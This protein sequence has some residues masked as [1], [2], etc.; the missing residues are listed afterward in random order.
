M[1]LQPNHITKFLKNET[2]TKFKSELI[3]LLNKRIRFLCFEECERDR[4]VC[5]LTP[6]C[7]KRFLLKL[8]IKNDLKIEDLPKFC[9][10]VHK[11]VIERDFRNKRVVYKPNDAFLYLIDFLDIF[12][13][14]DYRKLNKFMSF[15]NW[16]ESIKIF[17]D[18]IQNRNE[19]FKY[20]LTSNFFIFKFE[21]NVHIIFINEK[22]VLCNANRENITDLELLIGICRIFAEEYFPE[23]NLKFVPS[24]NV[25]ITVM[26]PYDVLSKVIDNPSEEF[27]SKA[28]EYFWNIFWEDLNTLTN[29][30]EEIHLQMDKNQNLEI[31]LSIS[32]LTNNY[33]DDGKRVPLRF[34]DLRLILNFITQIYTDY[35]IVW[36]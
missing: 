33:S 2:E 29:Y 24:K 6:L 28:D 7:S 16:E 12:F 15:R 32:L 27:N 23:I 36:V 13:H 18:R 25:E 11:G 14:G 21:Q 10:S 9:Y 17:D 3:D 26:V 4:I 8:R 22:Y 31:T 20:L 5:T 1:P 34:R 35:F 30:C 19:N